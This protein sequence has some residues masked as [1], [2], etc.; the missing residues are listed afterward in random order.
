M[1]AARLNQEQELACDDAV[2]SAGI[3]ADS[4]ANVLL[5]VAR[6]CSSSLLLGCA[7]AGSA[8]LRERLAHLFEW[9]QKCDPRDAEN[10]H[11]DSAAA[12]FC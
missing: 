9:R 1:L 7:M 2:L 5:D 4:Y 10:R 11:R 8:A 6:E 12:G 3:P